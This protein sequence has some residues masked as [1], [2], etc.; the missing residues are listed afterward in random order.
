MSDDDLRREVEAEFAKSD[1]QL[2]MDLI[3]EALAKRP[4]ADSA[5]HVLKRLGLHQLVLDLFSAPF[6]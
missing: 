3:Q 6:F 5:K 2:G 4:D 1:V